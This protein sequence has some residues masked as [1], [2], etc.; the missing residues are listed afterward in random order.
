[1][2]FLAA[3][4]PAADWK[5]YQQ[6]FISGDGRVLI[7]SAFHQPF[8]R[9]GLWHASALMNGDRPAFERIFRWTT[10]NLQAAVMRSSPGPG[11][12]GERRLKRHRLQQTQATA[13]SSSPLLESGEPLG[14]PPF[15][16]LP[17]E[18]SATFEVTWR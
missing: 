14:H 13:T 3:S 1:L 7:F 18:S 5:T 12:A 8:G 15:R 10:E 4:S 9:P 17:S 11:R 2:I 6:T 16:E